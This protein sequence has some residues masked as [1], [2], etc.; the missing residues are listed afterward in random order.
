MPPEQLAPIR[1]GLM[2]RR[3]APPP[4]VAARRAGFAAQMAAL[5]VDP[6]VAVAPLDCGGVP[7][8]RSRYGAASGRALL[9]LHGGAFVLGCAA[10]Y[11]PFAARLARACGCDV[12]VPD[13]RLAPEHTFPA[14]H[15]D[16][17]AALAALEGQGYAITDIAIGGD[18]CGANLALAAVQARIARG[19]AVPAALWLISPYLDLTHSGA[20]I[21]ARAARDPFIDPAGMPETARTYLA[22]ADPAAA[23]A[24]PLFGPVAGLP[25]TLIQIGSDEV[26]FD[27]AARLRE[28]IAAAGGCA[29][30]QEW[31]G[32]IHVWPLFA[33]AVDEGQWAIAQGG[34]F[35]GKQ[36]WPPVA[37]L[38]R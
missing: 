15:D 2:A 4:P 22:A 30:F 8:L 20:S 6:E 9:W 34:A 23:R 17:A 35:L 14:A 5:P 32:M 33:H 38:G 25:P 7:A 21:A 28:R 10:S 13:Y 26:L 29:V 18:S 1:A 12:I 36:G 16:A 11:R 24:S 3:A 31:A 37:S 19:A 27:D